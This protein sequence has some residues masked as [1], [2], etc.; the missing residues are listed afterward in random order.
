MKFLWEKLMACKKWVLV[1][2]PNRYMGLVLLFMLL[3]IYF[4][5][6]LKFTTPRAYILLNPGSKFFA[7]N[8]GGDINLLA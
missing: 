8:F 4:K 3:V 2:V 5:Q 7:H 1:T 6:S